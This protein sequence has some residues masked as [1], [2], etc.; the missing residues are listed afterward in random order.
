M[1]WAICE[2]LLASKAY[3]IFAT[4]FV[5]LTS[6]AQ[7]YLNVSNYHFSSEI[8]RGKLIFFSFSIF[9]PH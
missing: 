2:E 9:V 4:H 8:I 3:T 6:L 7:T 1:C 5:E